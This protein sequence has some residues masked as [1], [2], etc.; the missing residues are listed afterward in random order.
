MDAV[1]LS[2]LQFALTV[3]FHFLFPPLTFGLSLFILILET[4]YLK[5]GEERYRQLSDLF[6]KMLGLVFVLGTASGIVMEFSFGTNWS[7]YSRL[8]GDIFGAPLAAE[9]V[10][11]FFLESVFLGILVFGRNR[12]SK[13]A[14]W[15]SAL[16]VFF[17]SHLSGLWI[18]IANSWMQTPAGFAIE[19]NRAVLKDFFAAALNHSTVIR[20]V[21]TVVAGWITGTFLIAGVNAYY[22]LKN[23]HVDHAKLGLR[24]A[25]IILVIASIGE[26]VLGHLH[27]IQVGTTQ[28]EKLAAYEALYETRSGAP[29]ALFGIPN[30]EKQ[31]NYLYVGIPKALSFLMYF[32]SNATIKG[33]N[34]FPPDERPPVFLP[35]ISYHIMILLGFLFIAITVIGTALLIRGK[36][37]TTNWFLWVLLIAIPLPHLAN[38]FGWIAAEV[39]RQPWVVYRVLRTADAASVVVPAGQILFSLIMFGL[40][41]L[42]LF[43]VFIKVLVKIIKKG[44][45][46]VATPG[47]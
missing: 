38:Q 40:I 8:V 17:G 44:P 18:I 30:A 28:P 39:G 27:S 23:R 46:E 19:G 32:D 11:A 3:G 36:L 26:L 41:Y 16:L 14:Y 7:N 10:F 2:R 12:I 37:F 35:F 42:V 22:L 33:L 15:T 34:E 21:H 47:Y 24:I 5:K 45:A 25:M 31:K 20:Y 29:L 9:G 43:I 4:L 13:K 1:L 6:V